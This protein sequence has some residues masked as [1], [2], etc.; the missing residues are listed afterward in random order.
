METELDTKPDSVTKP[1]VP[2]QSDIYAQMY[3]CYN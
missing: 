1:D 3:N 2:W